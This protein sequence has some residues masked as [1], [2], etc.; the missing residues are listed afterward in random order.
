ML[1]PEEQLELVERAIE[2]SNSMLA[3]ATEI[4]PTIDG[5]L[6]FNATALALCNLIAKSQNIELH[7]A[8]RRLS[9]ILASEFKMV[10]NPC[11]K[12][13]ILEN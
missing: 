4:E 13:R 1:S 8:N 12:E 5:T 2:V 11:Y 10:A 7:E 3:H 6:L 9:L